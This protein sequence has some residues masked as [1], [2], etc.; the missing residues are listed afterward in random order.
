VRQVISAIDD[1]GAWVEPG[2]LRYHKVEVSQIIRSET[3]IKNVDILS[4]YLGADAG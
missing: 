3:F 4:R 2:K 1:R